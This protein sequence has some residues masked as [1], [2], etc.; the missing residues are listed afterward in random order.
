MI[1]HYLSSYFKISFGNNQMLYGSI[2][3]KIMLLISIVLCYK[4]NS[5]CMKTLILAISH[6]FIGA[7]MTHSGVIFIIPLVVYIRERQ[8][9]F[10]GKDNIILYIVILL[11]VLPYRLMPIAKSVHDEMRLHTFILE[12]VMYVTVLTVL[13]VN[14]IRFLSNHKLSDNIQQRPNR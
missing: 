2:I 1:L 4:S 9:E 14:I 5:L 3:S 8:N 12:I 11:L 7:M 13:I 10:S 6:T